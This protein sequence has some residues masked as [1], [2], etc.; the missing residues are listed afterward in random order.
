MWNK[1]YSIALAIAILAMSSLCFY[2]YSWLQSIGAPAAAAQNYEYFSGVAWTFLW[3]SSV[4]L[5]VLANALFWRI[6]QA[7]ALWA[8]FLYFA[9]FVVIQ[10]FL[11]DSSF[12]TFRNQ[13]VPSAAGKISFSPFFGVT[14]CVVGAVIAVPLM[15]VAWGITQVWNGEHEPAEMFRQKR[16]EEVR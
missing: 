6:R 10:T 1:T 7:W 4:V 13:Y 16:R 9:V 12:Q 5:L 2:A 14:L 3:L 11:L 8:T 15:A